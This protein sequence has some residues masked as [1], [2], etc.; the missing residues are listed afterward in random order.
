MMLWL[1]SQDVDLFC[2]SALDRMLKNCL[3]LVLSRL[4]AGNVIFNYRYYNNT[5]QRTEGIN[6]VL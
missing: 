3:L 4:R 1:L 2:V 6:D 5:L